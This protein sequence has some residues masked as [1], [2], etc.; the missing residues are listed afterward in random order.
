[1]KAIRIKK[2][3]RRIECIAPKPISDKF[4][5]LTFKLAVGETSKVGYAVYLEEALG[6]LAANREDEAV[7]W[8][9]Y[10]RLPL[11]SILEFDPQ[12]CE[13]CD[14]EEEVGAN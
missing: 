1:M 3:D 10:T 12:V 11:H 13:E 2:N 4:K 6:K 7:R 5:G 9:I 14:E 8:W